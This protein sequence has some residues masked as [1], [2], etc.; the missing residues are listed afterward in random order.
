MLSLAIKVFLRTRKFF[1]RIRPVLYFRFFVKVLI[2]LIIVTEILDRENKFVEY[3][4]CLLKVVSK[5]DYCGHELRLMYIVIGTLWK[6]SLL[7]RFFHHVSSAESH[8]HLT[9]IKHQRNL[10]ISGCEIFLF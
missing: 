10:N 6:T 3:H 1:R 7:T 4:Y 5:S 9:L 2:L 8:L